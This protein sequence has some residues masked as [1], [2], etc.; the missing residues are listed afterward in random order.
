MDYKSIDVRLKIKILPSSVERCR[1]WGFLSLKSSYKPYPK[2]FSTGEG[3]W[4]GRVYVLIVNYK[5]TALSLK[6][7]N[8]DQREERD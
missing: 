5:S 4:K 7:K 3:L 8:L 6:I 2:S 1:W